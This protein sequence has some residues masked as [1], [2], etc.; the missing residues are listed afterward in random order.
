M[1]VEGDWPTRDRVLGDPGLSHGRGRPFGLVCPGRP[2]GGV[3]P[4][5]GGRRP[6]AGDLCPAAGP[7]RVRARPSSSSR[8]GSGRNPLL[9]AA[10]PILSLAP[11]AAQPKPRRQIP[12][13]AAPAGSQGE[14]DRYQ[15]S[16]SR[17]AGCR[18]GKRRAVGLGTRRL[19]DDIALNTPWGAA[20]AWG[21]TGLV[22][23]IGGRR[24][25]PASISSR[26]WPDMQRSPAAT[27]SVGDLPSLPRHGLRGPLSRQPRPQT[28]TSRRPQVGRARP[29]RARRP[30][31]S[32]PCRPL[33]RVSRCRPLPVSRSCRPGWS[34]PRRPRCCSR[35]SRAFATAS[36]ATAS[37]WHRWC[38]VCRRS[39]GGS[40][41]VRPPAAARRAGNSSR[42]RSPA[43]WPRSSARG[44]SRWRRARSAC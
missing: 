35:S 37:S 11:H 39:S 10:L 16:R 24:P 43:S 6:P 5:P 33:G 20:S 9:G 38:G 44:W 26:R 12:R 15:S 34:G 41:P 4:Q 2:D 14:L 40:P 3:R 21:R 29:G 30:G 36:P 18:S 23:S 19:L 7:P 13:C 42:R 32:R 31:R 8:A 27:S 22:A 28:A 17:A 1:G 25:M